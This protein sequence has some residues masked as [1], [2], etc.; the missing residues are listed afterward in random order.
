[1]Q[2][3]LEAYESGDNSNEVLQADLKQTKQQVFELEQKLVDQEQEMLAEINQAERAYAEE[4]K[5][6]LDLKLKFKH[7]EQIRDDLKAT[8]H[9][10]IAE[11]AARKK[12][13]D[14]LYAQLGEENKAVIEALAKQHF[15]A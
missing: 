6:L 1:M 9:Q 12:F 8:Q 10:L 4:N 5:Q 15:G 11:T 14:D 13:V 2:S 7:D 3:K